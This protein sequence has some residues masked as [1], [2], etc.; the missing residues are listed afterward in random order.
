MN[1]IGIFYGS[2]TGAT[3][4]IA[5]HIEDTFNLFRAGSAKAVNIAYAQLDDLANSDYL[6]LGIPT[7]DIGE[8]Q[9]DWD[10]FF[11]H[12]DELNLTG[13]KVAIFGLG[14]QYGYSATFLD[15][16]GILGAKVRERGGQLVGYWSAAGYQVEASLALEG[17]HFIGLA[18]DEDNEADLSYERID[19]WV[20]QVLDEFG[21]RE[22][23]L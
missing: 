21:L 13:K 19:R 3:K 1:K 8:L 9:E 12:L 23:A 5:L 4:Y 15:A 17:D 16:M 14:D 2:S 11:P 6:V 20:Q 10:A 7:W 18:L 22:L